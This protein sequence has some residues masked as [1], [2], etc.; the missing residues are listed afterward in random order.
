MT[1]EAFDLTGQVAVITG[2]GTGIGR[3]SAR[4]LAQH[5]AD[6]VVASRRVENLE[7]TALDVE[8]VG[9]KA[10]VKRTDVRRPEDCEELLEDTLDAFGRLDILVNNAGGSKAFHIDEWSM[11]EFDKTMA[12]N[13]RSV[14]LLSRGAAQFMIRGGGGAIVNISSIAGSLPLRSL[15]PYGAAKAAVENLTRA[16][17]TEYGH[18]GIRVNSL[19]VGFVKSDGFIRSMEAI[20]RDPD[21]VGRESS[22]I[23]RAGT[24]EEVA[25]PVLFLV[26]RAASFVTGETLTVRGG[27]PSLGPW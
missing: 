9:R 24:P 15:A 16:M 22:S 18:G 10:L 8:R 21:E 19:A 6:V 2:G 7:R 20:G 17:A 26:S 12:L 14:F 3:A 13:F 23:G 4:L 25:Y 11:E 27:L 5:G 1:A